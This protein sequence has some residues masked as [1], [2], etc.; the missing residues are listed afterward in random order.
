MVRRTFVASS[1]TR[2]SS[3]QT[4]RYDRQSVVTVAPSLSVTIAFAG[5]SA[6]IVQRTAAIVQV[7]PTK[8]IKTQLAIE[9]E[10]I[11]APRNDIGD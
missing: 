8:G 9:Q 10:A 5:P 11:A 3:L 4:T 7:N 6:T 2:S 1:R